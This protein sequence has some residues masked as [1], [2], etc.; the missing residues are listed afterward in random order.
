MTDREKERHALMLVAKAA[1]DEMVDNNSP[2]GR[3]LNALPEGLFVEI[4][5]MGTARSSGPTSR[6]R[7]TNT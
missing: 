1:L 5:Q 3:A 2:A 4:S 6:R 7:R